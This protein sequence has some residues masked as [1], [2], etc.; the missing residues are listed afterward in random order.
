MYIFMF[1][2]QGVTNGIRDKISASDD[3]EKDEFEELWDEHCEDAEN[4]VLGLALS[5]TAVSALRFWI[6]GC[7]P[8][9][10]G[11]EE[12]CAV[13]EFIYFH[14]ALQKVAM[15]GLDTLYDSQ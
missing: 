8:N 12:E 7:L 4:D 15:I 10:E 13:E 11:K 5:F 9:Q 14:T 2:L 6:T 1:I 3:G